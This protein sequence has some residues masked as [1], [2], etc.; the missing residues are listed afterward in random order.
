[1]TDKIFLTYTI[2]GDEIRNL[3]LN[4]ID[5]G[6]SQLA[7]PG[8]FKK[9][10]VASEN[11]SAALIVGDKQNNTSTNVSGIYYLSVS[12]GNFSFLIPGNF[13]NLEYSPE[14]EKFMAS[15]GKEVVIFDETGVIQT[16]ANEQ[17]LT[18]SPNGD[19]FIGWNSLGARLYSSNGKLISTITKKPV[20][21]SI[22][23]PSTKGFY[24]LQS[25]DLYQYVLPSLQGK[26]VTQDVYAN[27][28]D[29]FVWL[30]GY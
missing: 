3:R 30:R 4:E 13:T 26:L 18:Y 2:S 15:N 9:I 12:D 11:E 24:L 22:W 16:V 1:M 21:A 17:R 19:Y 8:T 27:N 5:S 23:E 7:F 6:I 14:V 28:E 29:T 10:V 20:T 25:D